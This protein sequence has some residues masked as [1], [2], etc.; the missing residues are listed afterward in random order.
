MSRRNRTYKLTKQSSS[1]ASLFQILEDF[2][3]IYREWVN[4]AGK[5]DLLDVTAIIDAF[6]K[7]RDIFQMR[8]DEIQRRI[9]TQFDM[10]FE[11]CT[12]TTQVSTLI[13]VVGTILHQPLIKKELEFRYNDVIRL[14]CKEMDVVK[15]TF[16]RGV[17]NINN[18]GCIALPVDAG[19]SPV[20]G[21]IKWVKSLKERLNQTSSYFPHLDYPYVKLNKL[22]FLI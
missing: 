19:Q 15:K 6:P 8:C 10:A 1:S 16:D 11:Q 13:Q 4:I 14:F 5:Y 18:G 12:T 7:H 20:A 2:L 22:Y 3:V 21:V 17:R 9:A